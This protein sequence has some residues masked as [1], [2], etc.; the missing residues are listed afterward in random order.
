[1]I[2]F[3]LV[4][5]LW[6]YFAE[7]SLKD[8]GLFFIIFGLVWYIQLW[9]HFEESLIL[10]LIFINNDNISVGLFV[11]GSIICIIASI[12]DF[13]KIEISST[14][15]FSTKRTKEKKPTFRN[16]RQVKIHFPFE[17]LTIDI[18]IKNVNGM[19]KR[20][21]SFFVKHFDF[22]LE[23]HYPENV[24]DISSSD[25]FDEQ[26]YGRYQPTCQKKI[27]IDDKLKHDTHSIPI[28]ISPMKSEEKVTLDFKIV[29]IQKEP[30][31]YRFIPIA[32]FIWLFVP[33]VCS[34]EILS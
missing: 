34:F 9:K 13:T 10:N 3:H 4:E 29:A 16:L 25:C 31:K 2:E 33:N 7:R 17:P 26:Q 8:Y 11:I 5:K 19:K 27:K 6:E 18:I 12:R 23:F 28:Q 32:F 21:F 14:Y 1:M 15:P 30:K 24:I 22:F 20:I